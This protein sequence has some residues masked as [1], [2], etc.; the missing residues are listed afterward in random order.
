MTK[1]Q[2][3]P[4]VKLVTLTEKRVTDYLFENWQNK[5]RMMYFKKLIGQL[6]RTSY[7]FNK[8]KRGK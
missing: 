3:Q 5:E 1:E 8:S 2:E 7:N 6:E 4:K